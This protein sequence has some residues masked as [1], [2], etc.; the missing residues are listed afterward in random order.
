MSLELRC[1]LFGIEVGARES[2]KERGKKNGYKNLLLWSMEQNR[3]EIM[4]A[5]NCSISY[6]YELLELALPF[7]FFFVSSL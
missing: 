2:E 3:N 1:V 7:V 5:W 4:C 6:L